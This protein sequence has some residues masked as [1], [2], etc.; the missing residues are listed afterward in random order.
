MRDLTPNEVTTAALLA[1]EMQKVEA[2][3][4]TRPLKGSE[5]MAI[6]GMRILDRRIK[7]GYPRAPSLERVEPVTNQMPPRMCSCGRYPG[8]ECDAWPRCVHI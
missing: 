6:A 2:E 4:K 3:L 7:A 8:V 1:N 5:I